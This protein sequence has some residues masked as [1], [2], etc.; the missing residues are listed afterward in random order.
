MQT[1]FVGEPGVY[2][3]RQLSILRQ[4]FEEALR[5]HEIEDRSDIRAETIARRI[6]SYYARGE[7]DPIKLAR[8]AS[9]N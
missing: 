6:I 3:Q 2:D 5:M 1:D 9:A 8:V 4:A 7:N